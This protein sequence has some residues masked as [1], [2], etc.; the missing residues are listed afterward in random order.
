[1]LVALVDAGLARD[2]AYRLVVRT[3]LQAADQQR[4]FRAVVEEDA[5]LAGRLSPAALAA[6]FDENSLLRNVGAVIDRLE[7]LEVR[8]RVPA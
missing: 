2:A 3:A 4:A 6:C 1:V 5:E 8:A 7:Q